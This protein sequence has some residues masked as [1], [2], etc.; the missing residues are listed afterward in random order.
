MTWNS[1]SGKEDGE[2]F[3]SARVNRGDWLALVASGLILIAFWVS[4]FIYN[5][6][7]TR[8]DF[9]AIA[10]ISL[11]LR[12]KSILQLVR[13]GLPSVTCSVLSAV[14][15]LSTLV[16]WKQYF[17]SPHIDLGKPRQ[18]G[19]KLEQSSYPPLIFPCRTTHTRLFPAKHAFSYSY[20]YVGIPIGWRGDIGTIPAADRRS[21]YSQCPE[22]QGAWFSVEAEDY[23][24]R[25]GHADGLRGKL[26]DYLAAQ[27]VQQEKY[28][29]ALL[30]TAPR[31]LGFS[32]N[33]VS[34][35]YLYTKANMLGAM[36][37]EVNNTFDERRMYFME[38]QEVCPHP[39]EDQPTPFRHTWT[40]DFH[41]S[42]FNSRDGSYSLTVVDP[43][44]RFGA[45]NARVDSNIILKSEDGRVQLVARIFSTEP[46]LDAKRM[47]NWQ[48]A[49]FVLRW[50]WVGFMTNPRILR[51]AWKLWRKNLQ[52][53][54]R[55]EIMESSI[56][57]Q[58]T[59]EERELEPYVSQYLKH[60]V[61]RSTFALQLTYISAAG[62]ARG[63]PEIVKSPSASSPYDFRVDIEI[64]VLTPAFYSQFFRFQDIRE[65]FR[66]LSFEAGDTDKLVLVSKPK[67]FLEL[68]DEPVLSIGGLAKFPLR[69]RVLDCLRRPLSLNLLRSSLVSVLTLGASRGGYYNPALSQFD[70]LVFSGVIRGN[71]TTY[72]RY[73]AA[74]LFSD[75]FALGSILLSRFYGFLVWA[76]LVFYSAIGLSNA[77]GFLF[78]PK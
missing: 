35:W 11:G 19:G 46:A 72:S 28:P 17:Q 16:F 36:V 52:V 39:S 24:Q 4:R 27:G 77:V 74:L 54:F 48:T 55:P 26:Y 38:S 63:K 31:F 47:T 62:P 43:L 20:L 64:K 69:W 68:V 59:V 5:S 44:A 6:G 57:R 23:L 67:A 25:G 37:L 49:N 21:A 41:V 13:C 10:L 71:I 29:R 3:P 51:E 33:P 12:W 58:E 14:S 56:G 7:C 32:F 53:H 34:F 65:A 61:E 8:R 15:L 45:R 60:L 50:W 2:L 18:A 75:R 22:G 70:S 40:K 76:V 78:E 73:V 30:V 9:I 1:S 42:P 66:R